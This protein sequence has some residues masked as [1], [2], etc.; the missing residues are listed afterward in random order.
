MKLFLL[1]SILS[2]LSCGDDE[3]RQEVVNK[4]RAVGVSAEPG[5]IVYSPNQ[6]A[7]NAI[8]LKA[9][10]LLP[11]DKSLSSFTT[12]VDT[13]S[14]FSLP[15]P[16][17]I[18]DKEIYCNEKI[19]EKYTDLGPLK[20]CYI[21]ALTT[22]P[23]SLNFGILKKFNGVVKMRYGFD[24]KED[25]EQELIVGDYI[26]VTSDSKATSWKNHSVKISLPTNEITLDSSKE[27]NEINI[28]ATITKSFEEEVKVGWFISSG[29]VENFRAADT[30]WLLESSDKGEQTIVLGLYGTKS[31]FF[32]LDAR[33]VVVK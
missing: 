31:N 12:F 24:I 11:K 3:D 15:S 2:L 21:K 33:K 27:T 9:F 14:K 32:T 16:T 19:E 5:I 10:F 1:L 13:S 20:L 30:K 18:V 7:S 4:L 26:V 25:K 8:D 17:K 6:L 22:V 28:K 23:E 29:K